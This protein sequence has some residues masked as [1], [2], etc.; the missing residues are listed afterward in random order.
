MADRKDRGDDQSSKQAG[1]ERQL[2]PNGADRN[3]FERVQ[4]ARRAN[5]TDH[6]DDE[7]DG[8]LDSERLDDPDKT[9]PERGEEMQII[10][11]GHEISESERD[12]G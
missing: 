2:Y 10:G 8:N 12:F 6:G 11:D 1:D 9:K 4:S 3:S 5:G 7:G